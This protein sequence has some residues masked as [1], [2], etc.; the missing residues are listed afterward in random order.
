MGGNHVSSDIP[1]SER[2]VD[3]TRRLLEFV[4]ELSYEPGITPET[5]RIASVVAASH[6][7]WSVSGKGERSD[8]LAE[9]LDGFIR[10]M[11]GLARESGKTIA[12]GF[13]RSNR[14]PNGV[15]H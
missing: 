12:L 4:L 14:P 7:A 6:V 15:M 1:S 8:V 3:V 13:E 9:S 5:L 10:A 11:E 2:C